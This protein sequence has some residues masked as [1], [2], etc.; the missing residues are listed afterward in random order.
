MNASEENLKAETEQDNKNVEETNTDEQT[1][2]ELNKPQW[3]VVTFDKCAE[4]NLTYDE[5][6]IKMAELAKKNISGLC[7][8]TDK[9][10][11][12]TIKEIKL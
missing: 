9:A 3:S 12:N 2:S 7:I 10:S 8:V 4:K 1:Q 6:V 5:A 11:A